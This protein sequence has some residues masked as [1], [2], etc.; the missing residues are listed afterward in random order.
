MKIG[1]S[2]LFVANHMKNF[3]TVRKFQQAP[4]QLLTPIVTYL[5]DVTCV[6]VTLFFVPLDPK[7]RVH[8]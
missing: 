2:A 8:F 1:I 7:Y 4:K 6:T 5:V 3:V